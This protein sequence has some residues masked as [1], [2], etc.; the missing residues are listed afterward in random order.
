MNNKNLYGNEFNSSV[1]KDV[2]DFNKKIKEE[3]DPEELLKLRLKR[4][5]RGMELNG[6]YNHRSIRP[7]YPY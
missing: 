5:Y 7:Y 1:V 2:I 3:K 6:G 4:L